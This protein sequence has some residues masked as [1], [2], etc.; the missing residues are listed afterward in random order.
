[1]HGMLLLL[2]FALKE[3]T[4]VPVLVFVT[5]VLFYVTA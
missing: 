5:T 4:E 3:V 2:I 1:M